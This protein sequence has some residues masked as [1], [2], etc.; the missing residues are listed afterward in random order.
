MNNINYI[1]IPFLL[2][3]LTEFS[4]SYMKNMI[5]V[6]T[7]LIPNYL[8]CNGIF[9]LSY[10]LFGVT[11]W[12]ASEINNTEIYSL[13]WVLIFLNFVWIYYFKKNKKLS[14]ISLF[15]C[16]LFGYFTYNSI[17][18]SE[19]SRTNIT[20]TNL[21]PKYNTLYIDL[22]AIYMVWI[23]FMI[24][25]LIESSPEFMGLKRKKEKIRKSRKNRS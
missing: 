25:I 4:I 22:Y 24:T 23:G 1:Y 11:L 13:V 12:K 2:V 5:C 3:L 9:I 14:L 16:L 19:L 21:N 6:D 18:L 20:I 17:F 7:W 8:I 10:F 15:L